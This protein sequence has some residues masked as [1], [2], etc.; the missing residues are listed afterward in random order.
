[1]ALWLS[2]LVVYARDFDGPKRL[3]YFLKIEVAR[4]FQIH[5]T[6]HIVPHKPYAEIQKKKHFLF[7]K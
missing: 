2:L 3:R 5:T 7:K 4:N 6:Y 1:M